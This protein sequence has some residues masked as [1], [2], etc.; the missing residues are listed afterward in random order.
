MFIKKF[1]VIHYLKGKIIN[2]N[3]IYSNNI[4]KINKLRNIKFESK[5]KGKG[6]CG[7][8]KRYG[9]ALNYKT[10]GNSKAHRKQGS[11]GMC[12][13]PGKVIKGKKMPGR[14]GNKKIKKKYEIFYFDKRIII[15]KGNI[16]GS[17]NCKIN[18][19]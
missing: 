8:V 17:L 5:S 16:A 7:T 12:Q 19:K 2:L 6:F 10:H 13:D 15:V 11:I 14:L 9:F 1:M 3:I 4:I 18:K